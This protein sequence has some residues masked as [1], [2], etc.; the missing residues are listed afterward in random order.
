MEKLLVIDGNSIVNR[1]YYG[2][3]PLSTKSGIPTNAIYGFINIMQKYIDEYS[4]EYLLVAF[5]LKAPTF[6][7]KMY[8]EYKA[9][10]KGMPDDLA[11]QM[12]YLKDILSAMNIK[13]LSLEG[14][15]ADDIIGT[16]SRIC[17]EKGVW[18][19]II[20]GDKD[21]LQLASKNTSVLL[22]TSRM[23]QTSTEVLDED[24]V[25]EKYGVTPTEFISVKALMGDSSD[26][27]PGVR[28]IGEKTAF[29]I[30]KNFHTLDGLYENIGSPAI[31]KAAR[32]KLSCGREDA[33]M[34]LKLCT[35]DRFVPV[36]FCP[37]D[38]KRA[39]CDIPK[40]K[41]LL[42]FL[43]LKK[44]SGR[45]C[46][47]ENAV[48]KEASVLPA[49]E[50][51]LKAAREKDSFFFILSGENI[52]FA[53]NDKTYSCAKKDAA[54]ILG[55][56]RIEKVTCGYKEACTDLLKSG[57]TVRGSFYDAAVAA[58]LADPT[59]SDYNFFDLCAENS[60]LCGAQSLPRLAD[61]LLK[62]IDSRGQH[63]LLFDIELPLEKVLFSME[64]AGFKI[65]R[66]ELTNLSQKLGERISALEQSIYFMAG[67]PFNINSPKQLGKLLFEDM[68]L[69]AIK[70][71]K[72]GYS[73]D[74]GVLEK[75]RSKHEI[76]DCIIEYRHLSKLKSTYAD[77]FLPLLDENDRIHSTLNQTV[78]ATGRISSAEPN[79]Q[80]IPVRT[81]IG[82]EFRKIFVARE[83]CVLA[84]ADYSQ[85][86]LRV[87]AH[88]AGDEKMI[89]AFK[90]DEDIHTL[91]A[92]QVF[93]VAP[94]MVTDTMRQRAK[95][96]NF[97]I[98]YGQS[99]F[100]L[101]SELK[102]TRREAKEYIENY[103]KNYS[104]V[105]E[106]ME[107]TVNDA[108]ENG[109]VTTLFGRR[110]YIPEL[111]AKNFNMRSFGERAAMNTP[112]QGTAADII[113]IAMVKVYDALKK[114]CPEAS[115]ILQVHDELIC[116]VPV[117]CAEKAAGILKR[118]MEN[119]ANLSVPLRA[120]VN[121]GKSWYETKK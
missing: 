37:E 26:N 33:Y 34:C 102:I 96:V 83:G 76:I 101:S 68:G 111:K 94:F 106:Y 3:R 80:N 16:V 35:I 74:S 95:T 38:A 70:K 90:N 14:Y 7:H 78:T 87:L 85:I 97:G 15:E 25:F 89:S 10:R 109:F 114:E 116:E 91:T 31:K 73:T 64:Q 103:F 104:G 44:L 108:A 77:A 1:A 98:I 22:T 72:T 66:G 65:D 47:S 11:A 39:K 55:D 4:P 17:D 58:Y 54:D 30:I 115:L 88:M 60:L 62:L 18:C 40:L 32:E 43:E 46:E 63:S 121:I 20:T 119:A 99:E 93:G 13:Q 45:L 120:D 82:R 52:E 28:G 56:E 113:K 107:K 57:I 49:D 112:I 50:N 86:E 75:L 105:R 61:I 29:E 41:E 110:R 23:G 100:S 8:A 92:S 27:I 79:L 51:A 36:D 59:R 118:E 42:D 12:P 21:D 81:D 9:Q 67:A 19:G 71:T 84:G 117:H 53:L 69:P 2:V 24:G 5:D 6:R 48:P